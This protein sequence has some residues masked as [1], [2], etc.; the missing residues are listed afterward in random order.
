[1]RTTC[2]FRGKCSALDQICKS[3]ADSAERLHLKN[4]TCREQHADYCWVPHMDEGARLIVQCASFRKDINTSLVRDH[5]HT[6]AGH[7]VLKFLSRMPDVSSLCMMF[8]CLCVCVYAWLC[9]TSWM[10]NAAQAKVLCTRY[11]WPICMYLKHIRT[12]KREDVSLSQQYE[13]EHWTM[14]I[15]GP[16]CECASAAR[17]H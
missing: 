10:E 16:S 6:Q 3:K 12:W 14:N 2:R 15:V 13:D 17:R 9:P 11:I 7:Q 8:F 5:A 1:M 4:T